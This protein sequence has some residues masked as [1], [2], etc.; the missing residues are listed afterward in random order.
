MRPCFV[1]ALV[2]LGSSACY[3]TLPTHLAEGTEVLAPTKVGVTLAGGAA[4][5]DTKLRDNHG[6]V[7]AGAFEARVRVGIGNRQEVGG[8]IFAGGGTSV[9]N[10]DIPFGAG[11]KLSYKIAPTH[12]FA[13]VADGGVLDV[14]AASIV[15]P[16]GD[17][18]V[19]FA[20]YTAPGGTHIYTGLR[21]SFGIPILPGAHGADEGLTLP[22]GVAIHVSDR[23][24]LFVESGV[25][26]GFGQFA[27]QYG[28]GG[29]G[30]NDTSSVGGYGVLAF[31]Y[32][33]R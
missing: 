12:W 19:I 18:A 21:G 33:F 25:V 29:A 22:I 28:G 17:L 9:A 20:P 8:S 1:V 7:F 4:G 16:S 2:A 24:R 3:P 32:L 14:K 27:T 30:L 13:I 23:V 11:A 5:F 31:G 15:I 6:A 10:V 26:A